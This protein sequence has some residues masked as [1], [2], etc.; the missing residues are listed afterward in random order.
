MEKDYERQR[1]K[2]EKD[3][4]RQRLIFPLS[5]H[6]PYLRRKEMTPKQVG[7]LVF[8]HKDYYNIYRKLDKYTK[9]LIKCVEKGEIEVGKYFYYLPDLKVYPIIAN[10]WLEVYDLFPNMRNLINPEDK[11]DLTK[12]E[13]GLRFFS[14][15]IFKDDRNRRFKTGMEFMEPTDSFNPKDYFDYFLVL[16]DGEWNTVMRKK[17]NSKK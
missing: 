8:Y 14:K 16:R 7:N 12:D 17:V 1:K 9:L 2:M 5:V 3:Y 4:Q 10:S 13:L 11:T 6:R 15:I